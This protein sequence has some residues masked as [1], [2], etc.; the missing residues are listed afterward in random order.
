MFVYTCTHVQVEIRGQLL[1]ASFTFHHMGSRDQTLGS[2]DLE[3]KAF[4]WLVACLDRSA[5]SVISKSKDVFTKERFHAITAHNRFHWVS[6]IKRGKLVEAAVRI[7]AICS[8][9]HRRTDAE[10][11][12]G[13][14]ASTEAMGINHQGFKYPKRRQSCNYYQRVIL[15]LEGQDTFKNPKTCFCGPSV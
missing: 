10:R 8:R 12:N 4:T 15:L 11:G 9:V 1:G 7:K 2:W 14:Q 6:I 5:G 13:R 3:S